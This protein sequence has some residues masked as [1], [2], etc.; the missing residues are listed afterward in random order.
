M[1]YGVE[2]EFNARRVRF[3]SF[4]EKYG[5]RTLEVASNKLS[6]NV[7]WNR[8]ESNFYQKSKNS[9]SIQIRFTMQWIQ[10]VPKSGGVDKK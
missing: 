5:I 9:I 3:Q 7:R 6:K 4:K 1:N 8:F 10:I 2:V